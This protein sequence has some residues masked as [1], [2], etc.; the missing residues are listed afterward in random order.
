MIDSDSD[1]NSWL[2][3]TTP[4][5]SDSD[6]APLVCIIGYSSLLII[7]VL[8]LWKPKSHEYVSACVLAPLHNTYHK[9]TLKQKGEPEK[10][11]GIQL[12]TTSRSQLELRCVHNSPHCLPLAPEISTKCGWL[13]NSK[14]SSSNYLSSMSSDSRWYWKT[15]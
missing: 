3:A 11:R 14:W 13:L 6:S 7:S 8:Y 12:K 15:A 9:A 10:K 4:G 2:A 5:D 1:S